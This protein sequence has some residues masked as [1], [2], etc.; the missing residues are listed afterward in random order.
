M[1]KNIGECG[2]N[3]NNGECGENRLCAANAGRGKVRIGN[4]GG[5]TKGEAARGGGAVRAIMPRYDEGANSPRDCI[6]SIERDRDCI[7]DCIESIETTLYIM[8][9]GGARRSSGCRR[10]RSEGCRRCR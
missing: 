8:W 6:E 1:N 7:K 4:T 5:T 9:T 10:E 2:E 3:K